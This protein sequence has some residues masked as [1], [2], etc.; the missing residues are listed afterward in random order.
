VT[1]AIRPERL[2]RELSELWAQS[3]QEPGSAG[4]EVLRACSMTLMVLT[5]SSPDKPE[6]TETLGAL[7][8]VYPCRLIVIEVA[9]GPERRLEASVRAHCWRTFG[10]RRQVCIEQVHLRAAA[11]AVADLPPV[12]R[13]LTAPD[14]PVVLWC[15]QMD[16]LDLD[17][18][19]PLLQTA[20]KVIVDS[21]GAEPGAAFNRI[22]TL[23]SRGLLVADLAWTR[24]TRWREL[25]AQTFA[26][27]AGAGPYEV[28][29]ITVAHTG[30]APGAEALYLAGWLR[31]AFANRPACVFTA[32]E[33]PGEQAGGGIVAAAI[34]GPALTLTL[35]TL[36]EGGVEVRVGESVSWT[37]IEPRD[38][39]SLLK[40]ELAIEGPDP[41]FE[42]ALREAANLTRQLR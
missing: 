32:A 37:R 35:S 5:A 13:A 22:E 8:P 36:G 34:E 30:S 33:T 15:I 24:L 21:H 3:A 26:S 16:L 11:G 7:I 2:L 14:L 31:D 4:H 20:G 17:G 23:R 25:L 10:S 29:K 27:C 12:V 40:E 9:G 42:R 39:T 1:A 28:E 41:V 18:A 19:G 38:E 6:M